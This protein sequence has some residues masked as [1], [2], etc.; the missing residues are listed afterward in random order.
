MKLAFF[1]DIHANLPALESMF[2]DLDKVQPDAVY[3]LGD[4][5][6]Y[7]IW[8]NE[9]V[10]QIRSRRI[11]TLMG[12]HD[13]AL[14]FPPKPTDN[15]NRQLTRQLVSTEN[16]DFLI[17]LPREIK[18]NFGQNENR[19]NIW[20]VH[21]SPKAIN[22]Y[23]VEDY[24]AEEILSMME[25]NEADLLLCGHTHIPYHRTLAH[26]TGF[27]H[28]INTG[29]VGKPKDGDP[30]LCYLILT[31]REGLS[32]NQ[33]FELEFRRISYDIDLSIKSIL[34]SDFPNDLADKLKMAY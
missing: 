23:L 3:C 2:Q 29:S 21:G 28:I 24:P 22:D 15:V 11:P 4:L 13:E 8:P 26:A 18:L 14:I 12:N 31:L 9:V 16:K 32:K 34:E 19:L 5:V 17:Q 30:R 20:L 1:S 33:N 27:K 6:G 25:A 7:H 10:S